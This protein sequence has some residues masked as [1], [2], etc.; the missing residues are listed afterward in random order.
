MGLSRAAI[1][2][3]VREHRRSPFGRSVLTLGRMYV[4][5]RFADLQEILRQE[6]VS[7]TPLPDD[8]P[9]TTNIPAWRGTPRQQ[10]ASDVSLFRLLGMSDIQ[11]LDYSDFEGAELTWDLNQPVPDHFHGRFNLVVDSGTLEHVFDV[12]TALANI[13][14]M[15]RPGGR[16]LHMSPCNN[17]ANHGFYQFSPTFFLD[18]YGANHYAD[19]R[20]FVAE[21]TSN[22]YESSAWNLFQ[23][24]PRRLPVAMTS[25]RRLLVIVLAEK[26]PESTVGEIPVQCYYQSIWHSEAGEGDEPTLEDQP[27]SR[28]D[29]WKR[30]IPMAVRHLVRKYILGHSHGRPWGG[31]HLGRLS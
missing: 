25:K 22:T 6:G 29:K 7:P 17:Y 30:L 3:L 21:E 11:A 4:Y 13:N 19:I 20:V 23:I 9:R 14:R 10:N 27:R 12:R 16:V 15:L 5:A 28:A 1:R 8:V 26:Q 18:Y 31:K 24:D 2:F